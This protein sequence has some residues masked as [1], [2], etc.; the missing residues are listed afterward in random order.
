MG[1]GG[2]DLPLPPEPTCDLYGSVHVWFCGMATAMQGGPQAHDSLGPSTASPA[3]MAEES[4]GAGLA[5]GFLVATGTC[6][7]ALVGADPTNGCQFP[8]PLSVPLSPTHG[9]PGSEAPRN[10]PLRSD[11]HQPGPSVLGM[12]QAGHRLCLQ[13]SKTRVKNN[14][15]GWRM[16]GVS[17]SHL[18][19]ECIHTPDVE[20]T[21]SG[22][23]LAST[24]KMGLEDTNRRLLPQPLFF[25]FFS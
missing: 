23:Q 19:P 4:R 9:F 24:W 21:V 8:S 11:P 12:S 10:A 7:T 13:I 5:G 6:F 2:P 22:N 3:G 17:A 16:A 14:P 20:V 18:H 25:F 15:L 1:S